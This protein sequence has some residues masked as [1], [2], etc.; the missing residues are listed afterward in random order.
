MPG[1]VVDP[2]PG[3]SN[4]GVVVAVPLAGVTVL[5]L[6]NGG[7]AGFVDVFPP[8]ICGVTCVVVLVAGAEL[9]GAPTAIS[10]RWPG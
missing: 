2:D 6:I 10:Q 9:N 8:V 1:A 7:G 4:V 3:F 5:F